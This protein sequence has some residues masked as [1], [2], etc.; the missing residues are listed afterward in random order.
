M[1]NRAGIIRNEEGLQT[2]LNEIADLKARFKMV[3]IRSAQDLSDA[4][5]LENMLKVSEM[6]VRT[7]LK[8]TESRGAHYRSDYPEENN[9]LWLKNIEISKKNGS[10]S[11]CTVP[12]DL[13]RM[14][15]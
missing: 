13:S 4:L 9:N 11:L 8:R 15:P 6:V 2:A 10:M 12:T 1:W 14:A 3:S 7:A 5:K